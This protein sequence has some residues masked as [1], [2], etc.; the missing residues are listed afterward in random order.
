MDSFDHC[1]KIPP[2]IHEKLIV[3][4]LI[5]CNHETNAMEHGECYK[6]RRIRHTKVTIVWGRENPACYNLCYYHLR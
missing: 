2:E 5:H 4:A 3:V 6:T 1:S